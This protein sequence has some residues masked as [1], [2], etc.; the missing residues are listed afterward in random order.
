MCRPFGKVQEGRFGGASCAEMRLPL[1]VA[2]EGEE[3]KS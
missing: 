1:V 2:G 3:L